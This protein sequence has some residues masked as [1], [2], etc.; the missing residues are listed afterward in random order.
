M[1]VISRCRKTLEI[2][3]LLSIL[4]TF[5]PYPWRFGQKSIEL[6]FFKKLLVKIFQETKDKDINPEKVEELIDYFRLTV[7][8]KLVDKYPIVTIPGPDV[9]R[10]KIAITDIIPTNPAINYPAMAV[11][12]FPM[13]ISGAA[14]EMEF[15]YLETNEVVDAMVNKKMGSPFKPRAFSK[16]G[17]TRAAFDSWAKE[18]KS[19]RHQS[20]IF[21]DQMQNE[22]QDS[23][24]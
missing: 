10:V 18:L 22:I 24:K 16:L 7:E 11:V 1:N 8:N 14:I 23:I 5:A 9:L 19:Y 12:F 15:L 6:P 21:L 13:D 4:C 17:Y 20:I 3:C 2:L